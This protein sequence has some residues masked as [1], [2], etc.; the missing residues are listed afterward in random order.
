MAIRLCGFCILTQANPKNHAIGHMFYTGLV[1]HLKNENTEHNNIVYRT[2]FYL[3]L[4]RTIRN[5]I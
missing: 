5:L 2:E 1:A 3:K 4:T